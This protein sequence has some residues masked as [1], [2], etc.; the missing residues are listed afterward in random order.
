MKINHIFAVH[1]LKFYWK[2][3]ETT[4]STKQK[5]LIYK[6]SSLDLLWTQS[7]VRGAK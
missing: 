5:V 1:K 3:F 6:N 4:K 7:A 2:K